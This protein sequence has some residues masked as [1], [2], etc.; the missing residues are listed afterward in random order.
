[1]VSIQ[2]FLIPKKYWPIPKCV[3]FAYECTLWTLNF[4][5]DDCH[6]IVMREAFTPNGKP[7]FLSIKQCMKLGILCYVTLA[8]FFMLYSWMGTRQC[9]EIEHVTCV[10][11]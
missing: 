8:K 7:I 1:M 4:S 3:Y 10:E 11:N 5:T 2:K 6:V 9:S